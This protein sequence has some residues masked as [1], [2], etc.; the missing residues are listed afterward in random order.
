MIPV[1]LP[2]SLRSHHRPSGRRR[3]V[4][5][6]GWLLVAFAAVAVLI[7]DGAGTAA[8]GAPLA[9]DIGFTVAAFGLVRWARATKVAPRRAALS[10]TR[11]RLPVILAATAV[12]AVV[13]PFLDD[14]LTHGRLL[15]DGLSSVLQVANWRYALGDPLGVAETPFRP[16]WATS[17]GAQLAA[18]VVV[19]LVIAGRRPLGGRTVV[20]WC[21][22]GA[23]LSAVWTMVLATF[24]AMTI[25]DT[26]VLGIDP[27]SLPAWLRRFF[28][29]GSDP[30]Q[31][32]ILFG[33]DTR[34]SAMFV[35]VA[36]AVLV[37]G[38]LVRR[39]A[40]GR[41][42][43]VGLAA[44]AATVVLTAATSTRSPWLPYGAFLV[45]DVLVALVLLAAVSDAGDGPLGGL[46]PVRWISYGGAVA[47]AA[48]V[49]HGPLYALVPDGRVDVADGALAALLALVAIG[50]GLAWALG[51]ER[52]LHRFVHEHPERRAVLVT[53]GVVIV[54][55]FVVS[56][57]LAPSPA[58]SASDRLDDGRPNVVFAGDSMPYGLGFV[59]NRDGVDRSEGTNNALAAL[60]G[61]GITGGALK[62]QGREQVQ[63]PTCLTWP[64]LWNDQ[65][66]LRQPKAAVL[67]AWAWELYDR[68]VTEGGVDVTYEVGTPEWEER[69]GRA[70][71][72]GIDVLSSKDAKVAML[73]MPCVDA[74][75]DAPSRPTSEATE[76]WRVDAVNR[77]IR[78][79][80]AANPSTTFVLDLDG[81]LCPDGKHYRSHI[82][83]VLMTDDS[84]HF[85]EAGADKIWK[86][87]LA[88]QLREV[89]DI[90]KPSS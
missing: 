8:G 7:G 88:P 59:T 67:L 34:A 70:M 68:H 15:G 1:E 45:T 87:W 42:R 57:L 2:R 9:Y 72:T 54:V 13:W 46:E 77:L 47:F 17:V 48:F 44:A 28:D 10:E 5:A 11:S 51:A 61:C 60:P 55:G 71:Q 31:L 63:D 6:M 64:D 43:W 30:E 49:W 35:G 19:G 14:L 4:P 52:L 56:C 62:N 23:V 50:L 26:R 40:P 3:A 90:D 79:V 82:D 20:R 73:T 22:A 33:T 27:A 58:A 37:D 32:R 65:V 89:L 21:L 83:G 39:L 76:T 36:A 81:Y 53:V 66:L 25:A 74:E 16:L 29:L 41:L 85:S 80:A 75:I 12:V 69:L 18:L 86:D 38:D 24:H 78:K 84:V